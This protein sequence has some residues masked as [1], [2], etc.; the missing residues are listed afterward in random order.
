MKV[1]FL[2]TETY[3]IVLILGWF[4][5]LDDWEYVC[6]LDLSKVFFFTQSIYIYIYICNSKNNYFNTFFFK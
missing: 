5:L 6:N 3:I 2:K 4:D 1:I